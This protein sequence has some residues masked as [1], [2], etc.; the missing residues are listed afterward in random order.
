[1]LGKN[2]GEKGMKAKN[3]L[4]LMIM[5]FYTET[6]KP[7]SKEFVGTGSAI[8]ASVVGFS[9]YI[10]MPSPFRLLSLLSVGGAVFYA[11]RYCLNYFTPQGTAG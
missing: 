9:A 6:A 2:K 1:M 3:L 8:A 11:A 5:L 10:S 7:I 4:F